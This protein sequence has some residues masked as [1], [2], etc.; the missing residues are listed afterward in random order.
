MG[1]K[2]LAGKFGI[3]FL[4]VLILFLSTGIHDLTSHTPAPLMNELSQ[5]GW[6]GRPAD[7]PGRD[8]CNACFCAQLLGQ[9]LFPVN[10]TP[11]LKEFLNLRL[12]LSPDTSAF[13][14][15]RHEATRGP[16]SSAA[17]S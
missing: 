17:L 13:I 7:D 14:P 9:C 1:I 12:L 11:L 2:G 6:S 10:E 4:S 8:H 15:L 5:D 3:G 16:P